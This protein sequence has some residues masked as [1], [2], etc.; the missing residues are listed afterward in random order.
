MNLHAETDYRYWICSDEIL[1]N[2]EPRQFK[3]QVTYIRTDTSDDVVQ[4][5]LLDRDWDDY[6]AGAKLM[7]TLARVKAEERFERKVGPK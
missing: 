1:Y 5:E 7:D 6:D 2:E 4:V 3:A